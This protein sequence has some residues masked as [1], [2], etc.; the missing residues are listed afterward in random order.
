ML[1]HT[2]RMQL[3]QYLCEQVVAQHPGEILIGGV[4]GSAARGTDTP[5]S[6]LEM[7]FV[8]RDSCQAQE[9]HLL[10]RDT[11]VGYRVY[12]RSVLEE[13]LTTPSVRWPFH[14]GVLCEL[15]LLYGNPA[16]LQ[17]WI[18]LGTSIERERFIRAL[19]EILPDLVVE[20]HGRIHSSLERGDSHTLFPHVFEVLFEMLTALC[21]LNQRWVTRDYY[22]GL[23]QSFEFPK[24]P[25]GYQEIVPY[26]YEAR[27]PEQTVA[28]ADRLVTNY[29]DLLTREGVHIPNYQNL[30]E[31]IV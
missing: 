11:A 15:Q 17:S 24:L 21:L 9:G 7:W 20:S 4:Y 2:E 29:W 26:L 16:T 14:M 6:D 27:V 8:T 5:W 10:Y 18:E 23:E 28:L 22:P 13:I 30:A 19:E 12:K 25:T 31:I 3:A 1:T